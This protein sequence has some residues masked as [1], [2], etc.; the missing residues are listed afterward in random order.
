MSCS[1]FF[2]F[3]YLRTCFE[4]CLHFGLLL[5][6]CVFIVLFGFMCCF[7][8]VDLSSHCFLISVMTPIHCL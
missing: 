3:K 1:R 5:H 2:V 8:N 4:S 6:I 7:L